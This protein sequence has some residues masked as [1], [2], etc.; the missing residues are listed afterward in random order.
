MRADGVAHAVADERLLARAVELDEAAAH[1]GG[2]VGAQRLIQRVLLVAEA[3]A[4]IRLDDAYLAPGDAESLPDDAADDV[5]DLCG[6]VDDDAPASM[7]AKHM[8]F[9]M[10]QCCTVGVSYQL[11]P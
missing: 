1:D 7:E 9:S 6:G 2:E 3:A 10:W 4:D 5:R 11:R 8:W